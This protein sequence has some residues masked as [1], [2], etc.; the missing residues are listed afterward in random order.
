MNTN[1][2]DY[3]RCLT[4]DEFPIPDNYGDGFLFKVDDKEYIT[5]GEYDYQNKEYRK[6]I[7][8]I[9]TFGVQHYYASINIGV[10]NIDIAKPTHSIFGCYCDKVIPNNYKSLRFE[11]VRKVTLEEKN[12]YPNR[13]VGYNIGDNTDA[14]YN[15][16]DII[17]LFKEI[18]PS[19]L[20]GKWSVSIKSFH[21]EYNDN[22]LV[23]Y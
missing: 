2:Q 12:S 9:S 22:F 5:K 11:L 18:L 8:C 15:E 3:L 19:M 10:E 1:I 17:K 7:L 21:N 23:K 6:I 20:I 16:Y 14:F 13:W 4:L